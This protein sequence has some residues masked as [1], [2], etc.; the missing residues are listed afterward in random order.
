MHAVTI[1]LPFKPDTDWDLVST[2]FA[3][4]IARTKGDYPKLNTAVLAK[5]SP[6]EG[7]FTVIYDDAETMHHVS[8]EIAPAWFNGEIKQ[9]LAGNFARTAGV[10]VAGSVAGLH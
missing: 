8:S 2:K 4:F 5:V 10:V 3:T 6:T 7:I 9:H 1:R